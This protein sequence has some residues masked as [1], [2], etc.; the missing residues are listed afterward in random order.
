MIIFIT[1]GAR[2]GK[3]SF[4]NSLAKKLSKDVV[5][6]ATCQSKDKEMQKRIR[7]HR[8]KRAKNWKTIEEP[9]EI[10][11]VLSNLTVRH[12]P[13]TSLRTTL[14]RGLRLNSVESPQGRSPLMVRHSS[15]LVLLDCLTLL[16]SNLMLDGASERKILSKINKSLKILK[17]KKLNAIIV[18]NEVGMGIVPDNSLG[19]EFRDLQ[20]QVNQMVAKNADK[21]YLLVSGIAVEITSFPLT[22][23]GVARNDE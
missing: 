2:S 20:G 10:D 8:A 19:R 11:K 3:S 23:L 18:S 17:Q 15:P 5:Y 4:A 7:L 1:G 12:N 21:V 14:R 13:S 6:F 9:K 22:M 16:I